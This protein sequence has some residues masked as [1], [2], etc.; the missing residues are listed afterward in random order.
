M[1]SIFIT[2]KNISQC[3]DRI[4]KI[5]AIVSEKKLPNYKITQKFWVLVGKNK[6]HLALKK[7]TRN[8]ISFLGARSFYLWS[9]SLINLKVL[10]GENFQTW[11][12]S[13]ILRAS[14]LDMLPWAVTSC[15]IASIWQ[16]KSNKQINNIKN[17]N[18]NPIKLKAE[19]Q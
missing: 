4:W 6:S 19:L 13:R 9:N 17:M 14:M 1:S 8:V 3:F 15:T 18:L 2:L 7:C 16:M 11:F 12:S 5:N 10:V